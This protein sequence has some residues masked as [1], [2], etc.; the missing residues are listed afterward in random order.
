MQTTKQKRK[1]FTM[2]AKKV[3]KNCSSF[4]LKTVAVSMRKL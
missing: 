3:Q 1:N 2:C 4:D